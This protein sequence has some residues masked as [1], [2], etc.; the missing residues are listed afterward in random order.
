V[1]ICNEQIKRLF[2][3]ISGLFD[4]DLFAMNLMTEPFAGRGNIDVDFDYSKPVYT[5]LG[6]F[7]K[8]YSFKQKRYN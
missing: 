3:N 2:R 5:G 6:G 8:F 4:V 7:E 1:V